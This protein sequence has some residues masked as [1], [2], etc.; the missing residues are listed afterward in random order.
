MFVL[1]AKRL[2]NVQTSQCVQ[3]LN[4]K[5][6]PCPVKRLEFHTESFYENCTFPLNLSV[7]FKFFLYVFKSSEQS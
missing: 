5:Y 6:S 1:Y 4:Q 7:F 3:T 2:S